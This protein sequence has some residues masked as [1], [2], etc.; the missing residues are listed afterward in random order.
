MHC[1][2]SRELG[3]SVTG[4]TVAES[5]TVLET[6]ARTMLMSFIVEGIGTGWLSLMGMCLDFFSL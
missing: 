6:V 5:A 2:E 3:S 1:L 4:R